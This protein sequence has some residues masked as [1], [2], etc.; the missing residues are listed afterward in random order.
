MTALDR[1]SGE[2]HQDD[3]YRTLVDLAPD[4]IYSLDRQGRFTSLSREF[5]AVTGW[6]VDE[7]IGR[8]FVDLIHPD[9]LPLVQERFER[10]LEGRAG[11]GY[12]S[13]VWR[14]SGEPVVVEIRGIP[15]ITGDVVNGIVGVARDITDRARAEG[16]L[17]ARLKQ[18]EA[19]AHIGQF[20]LATADLEALYRVV[21]ERVS[22]VLGVEFCTVLELQPDG[23]MLVRRAWTGFDPDDAQQ[24]VG[25]GLQSQAGYTLLQGEPVIVEDMGSETRFKVP[26]IIGEYGI[27]SGISVPVPG[28]ETPRAVLGGLTRRERTFTGD[29]VHFLESVAN[30]LA[31]AIERN[32]IVDELSAS[33]NQL[34]VILGAVEDGITVQRRDG[35]LVYANL[36]AAR[37]IGFDRLEDLLKAD[38]DRIASHF[39]MFDE[40]GNPV[41]T[42][43]L[44]GRR[45]IRD[46]RPAEMQLRFRDQNGIEDHWSLVRSVPVFDDQGVPQMAVTVFQDISARM[47]AES[48]QAQLAALVQWSDDAI[49]GKDLDAVIVSWNPAA[50]RLY[51]YSAAEAIGQSIRLIVP[52][53]RWG[54][55]DG[56]MER[57]GQGE[58]V[59]HFD[60]ERVR[61]DGTMLA[62]SVSVSPV[63]DMSG[64]VVGAAT[65]ARDITERKRRDEERQRL[66]EREHAA[67]L[68]MQVSERRLRFLAEAS[69]ALSK[70]LEYD[71]TLAAVARLAVPALGDWCTIDVVEE[72]GSIRR[73][74]LTNPDPEKEQY[75][76]ELE[77]RY[78]PDLS[79]PTNPLQTGK[80]VLISDLSAEMLVAAARDEEHL[81]VLQGLGLK[82]ALG[83]PLT[84]RGRILGV[85]TL[86]SAESGLTY[87]GEDLALA[88]DLARRA[89]IAVDNARL[90]RQAQETLR[91]REEFLSI[92][93]HELKTPLTALQLQVQVLTRYLGSD[94]EDGLQRG[95]ALHILDGVERQMKRLSRLV[96]DLLD[97]S[98]IT[99]GRLDLDVQ[100]VDLRALV[101][102]VVDRFGG[103]ARAAGSTLTLTGEPVSLLCDPFRLDQVLTNLISNAIRYG[104]G[105]PI[106]VTVGAGSGLA[107]ISV[108]DRGIG[109]VESQIPLVFNRFERV[110]VSHNYGGLGLGLYIVRQI[111]EAHGGRILVESTVG[112]GSTFTVELPQART[113]GSPS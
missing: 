99:A 42:S 72:D 78:P 103:E 24:Q 39:A 35:R 84:A 20:A 71:T 47:R 48:A 49:I 73:I 113:D 108:R 98:R 9:D 2:V 19:V 82:S 85:L 18:Q 101:A 102:D 60:T 70:S 75:A 106:D 17:E 90:Y 57:V 46:G 55:V 107:R 104:E 94:G 51:G 44:P 6:R 93:S 80:P 34:Q 32:H 52:P 54:E 105:R 37:L 111:V 112:E 3:H 21:T 56:F 76:R 61:K 83:V 12:R 91:L 43:D 14:K 31:A 95:R 30:V 13:R 109:I 64:T 53:D 110:A 41:E 74:A 67:R 28:T 88:E 40:R 27:R 97:V 1:G 4:V 79:S 23:A 62:V 92:A 7:W 87:D 29:D 26:D 11:A 59:E 36:A 63:K 50:E 81:A 65:I 8:P 86:I 58:A 22:D 45:V 15:W 38:Y 69:E 10:S 100:D 66:L 25:V 96:N 68:R 16:E 33:R 77:S 89:A 5:E